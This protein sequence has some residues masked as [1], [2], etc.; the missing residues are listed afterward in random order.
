MAYFLQYFVNLFIN[1]SFVSKMLTPF[2]SID[3][4]IKNYF[5]IKLQKKKTYSH[6]F[7]PWH[8]PFT[9]FVNWCKKYFIFQLL[10]RRLNIRYKRIPFVKRS[11]FFGIFSTNIFFK[12]SFNCIFTYKKFFFMKVD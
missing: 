12:T 9:A 6:Y 3:L 7:G 4:I 8:F 1:F 5:F 11:N 10:W 2:N